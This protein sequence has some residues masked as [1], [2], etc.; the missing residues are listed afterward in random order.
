MLSIGHFKAL[1]THTLDS[2]AIQPEPPVNCGYLPGNNASIDG[3]WESKNT[4]I[5]LVPNKTYR[6]GNPLWLVYDERVIQAHSDLHND[7][8]KCMVLDLFNTFVKPEN[9]VFAKPK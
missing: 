2:T 4:G 9:A 6:K 7:Y 3:Y 8:M 5:K 1:N